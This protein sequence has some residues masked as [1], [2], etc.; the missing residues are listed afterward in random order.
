MEILGVTGLI[1]IV[2]EAALDL[3]LE[4]TKLPLISKAFFSALGLLALTAGFIA[5]IFVYYFGTDFRQALIHAI[6]LSVISSAIAIP[7]V[8]NMIEEKKEF[9]VYESTFSDILGIVAFNYIVAGNSSGAGAV[10]SFSWDII[11]II[12]ISIASTISLIFLLN[13]ATTHV[14][15]YLTFAIIVLAYSFAKFLHLPSLILVLCFGL[16]IN[17]FRLFD[18]PVVHRFLSFERLHE[19][20]R[21]LKLMTAETAFIIRTFFFLIFGYSVNVALLKS[22]EVIFIGLAIIGITLV[23]RYAFLKYL[24]KI[25]SAPLAL[26]APRGLITILLFYSIPSELKMKGL[27]EGVL[28]IVIVLTG[29]LMT[30]GL[31][32]NKKPSIE[33]IEDVI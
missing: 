14:R 25:S 6:P 29:L 4:K 27:S 18:F 5:L 24:L 22:D 8:A 3:K 1:F 20:T 15:F 19:V 13:H 32:I 9:V 12:V 2:L 33:Q 10:L 16:V 11:L 17:N 31:L 23:V 26:I 30:V 21:E 7:S 28:F